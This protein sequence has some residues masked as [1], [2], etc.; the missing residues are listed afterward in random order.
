[1]HPAFLRWLIFINY[2][3]CSLLT[4]VGRA[5]LLRYWTNT[6]PVTSP[7]ELSICARN[8]SCSRQLRTSCLDKGLPRV[9][10]PSSTNVLTGT[11]HISQTATQNQTRFFRWLSLISS[12]NEAYYSFIVREVQSTNHRRRSERGQNGDVDKLLFMLRSLPDGLDDTR[13]CTFRVQEL[14]SFDS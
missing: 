11:R 13:G 2:C 3:Q 14:V 5:M 9:S 8:E 12:L 4:L 1:M 10:N 7:N 6:S